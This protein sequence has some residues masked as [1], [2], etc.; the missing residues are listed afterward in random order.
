MTYI[1]ESIITKL[2]KLYSLPRNLR[3]GNKLPTLFFKKC[4]CT[5]NLSPMRKIFIERPDIVLEKKLL[6][7]YEFLFFRAP[8]NTDDMSPKMMVNFQQGK[9]LAKLSYSFQLLKLKRIGPGEHNSP[10]FTWLNSYFLNSIVTSK[11]I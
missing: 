10:K 2:Q 1:K 4:S 5:S 8:K 7:H 11:K 3:V 9:F 6:L